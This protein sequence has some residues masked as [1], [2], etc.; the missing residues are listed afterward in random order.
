MN[1]PGTFT[2]EHRSWEWDLV[3]QYE[4]GSLPASAWNAETLGA[5]A[6]WYA[7]HVTPEQARTR[8]EL[9]YH[10][11]VR[12]LSHRLDSAAIAT[13]AIKAVD[14]VWLSILDHALETH[15]PQ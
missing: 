8:Y 13:R 6:S 3:L 15:A 1:N 9:Y 7:R 11:N 12:R 10:R 4:D 2:A 5:V 14:E